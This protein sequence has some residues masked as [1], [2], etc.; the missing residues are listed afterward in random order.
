M[1][2]QQ[3]SPEV[4][5]TL[6][7]IAVEI[8]VGFVGV[9]AAFAL[10]AYHEQRDLIER[11]HQIKRALIVEIRSLSAIARRNQGYHAVLATFDSAVKAGK[12]PIPVAYT[13]AVAVSPHVWEATKQAGGLNLIDVPTFVEASNFYNEMSEMLG[14]YAQLRELS[15]NVI[16]PASDIGPDAFYNKQT[17]ALRSDVRRLYYWDLNALENMARNA[18]RHGDSLVKTLARDTI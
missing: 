17:G 6:S 18:A 4:R 8:V 9:Y 3:P 5:R 15:V 1:P 12:K 11:R 10:S 7:R 14:F 16:L 2:D 13:E